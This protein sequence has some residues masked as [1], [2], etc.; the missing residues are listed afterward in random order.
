M[1][2]IIA[3]SSS[4]VEDGE[5]LRSVGGGVGGYAWS[6]PVGVGMGGYGYLARL[7]VDTGGMG[8]WVPVWV[9]TPIHGVVCTRVGT[10]VVVG[11]GVW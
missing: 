8:G 9:G 7:R 2:A 10:C 6:I 5:I 1:K 11:G 3:F 4:E